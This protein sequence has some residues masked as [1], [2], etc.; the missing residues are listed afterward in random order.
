MSAAAIYP[1]KYQLLPDLPPEM[2]E[3]L[4]TD[5]AARGVVT[6][7]DVDEDGNILDGHNRFRA[8]REL[9][10]NEPPP[11][12]VRA[13]LSED[14]KRA[15]ARRQNVL[16]RH[17]NRDQLRALV[18]QQLRETPNW[19]NNRVAGTIGV[20]DKTVGAVRAQLEATSELP[21][22]DKLIGADGKERRNRT[23]SARHGAG[24]QAGSLPDDLKVILFDAGVSATS[25]TVMSGPSPRTAQAAAL[26]PEQQAEWRDF[27]AFLQSQ[28]GFGAE[29]AA[30]H[31]QWL[32]GQAWSPDEWLGDA[33]DAY[34]A[35][36]PFGWQQLGSLKAAWQSW[37]REA[38]P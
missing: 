24:S 32:V 15:F 34:R 29:G 9:R 4:K 1:G 17:L 18:A 6:P 5:I 14:E 36:Y 2:F 16:R 12:I 22:F 21:K 30:D 19:A 13:G 38:R 11:T 8:W 7:I 33:G 35:R 28:C 26:T 3:A 25:V 10:K 20:D 31:I 27:G 23:S 37:P